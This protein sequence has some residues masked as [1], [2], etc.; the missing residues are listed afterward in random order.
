M[1][2]EV[3]NPEFLRHQIDSLD[4]DLRSCEASAAT[5]PMVLQTCREIVD[6][7]SFLNFYDTLDLCKILLAFRDRQAVKPRYVGKLGEEIPCKL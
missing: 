4:K 2:T 6:S 7:L 1:Q 3:K 5:A